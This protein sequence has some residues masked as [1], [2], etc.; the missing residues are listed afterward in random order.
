MCR[1]HLSPGNIGYYDKT[2]SNNIV[3][4]M[5]LVPAFYTRQ[6]STCIFIYLPPGKNGHNSK[7]DSYSTKKTPQRLQVGEDSFIDFIWRSV[8]GTSERVGVLL[9][10]VSVKM[11]IIN[12]V[13]P[14][15]KQKL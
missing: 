11:E 10:D 4:K 8:P 5:Q 9:L 7:T 12:F 6:N 3:N 1:F 2:D 13:Q 14:R 15:I